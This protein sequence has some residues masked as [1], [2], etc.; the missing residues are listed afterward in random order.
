MHS[1][2]GSLTSRTVTVS[3]AGS[4]ESLAAADR[5]AREALLHAR[6][7]YVSS[8]SANSRCTRT[9]RSEGRPSPP[10]MP[11]GPRVCCERCEHLSRTV[12][13]CRSSLLLGSVVRRYGPGPRGRSSLCADADAAEEHPPD[14]RE[15]PFAAHQSRDGPSRVDTAEVA[16]HAAPLVRECPH[17]LDAS[18]NASLVVFGRWRPSAKRHRCVRPGPEATRPWN[19]AGWVTSSP[20]V[21]GLRPRQRCPAGLQAGDRNAE[22]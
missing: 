2:G 15:V 13:A 19:R 7:V 3:V 21:A 12:P 22:R 18:R 8:T 4:P 11:T 16:G 20:A 5:A 14:V 1:E 10:G 17:P 6:P 9:G